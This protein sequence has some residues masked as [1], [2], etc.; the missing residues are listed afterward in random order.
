MGR[1]KRGSNAGTGLLIVL[2]ALFAVLTAV[3]QF[4]MEHLAAVGTICVLLA[5][6][7]F[8]VRF[9]KRKESTVPVV[10]PVESMARI[11]SM[12]KVRSGQS[13]AGA[14]RDRPSSARCGFDRGNS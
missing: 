13:N 4:V 9:G 5:L 3:Y 10:S 7:F 12:Q 8:L 6:V 14:S 11:G 1:R 2:G